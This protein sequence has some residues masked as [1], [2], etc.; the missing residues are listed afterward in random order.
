MSYNRNKDRKRRL[1]PRR[2]REVIDL[3]YDV[4]R[5]D[6]ELSWC[7][8]RYTQN[9]DDY[10]AYRRFVLACTKADKSRSRYRALK[11]ALGFSNG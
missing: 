9:P 1:L 2:L 3:S 6:D 4:N 7:A 10:Q 11:K 8:V 5:D